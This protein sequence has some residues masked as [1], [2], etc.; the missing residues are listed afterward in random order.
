MSIQVQPINHEG[1]GFLLDGG[2]ISTDEDGNKTVEGYD[3]IGQRWS[4]YIPTWVF[5]SDDFDN[6][7][8]VN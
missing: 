7:K 5:T 6:L 3:E 2:K 4:I 8:K 1:E